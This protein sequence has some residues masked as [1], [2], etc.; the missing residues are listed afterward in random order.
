[1]RKRLKNKR[2]LKNKKI[3]AVII[4]LVVFFGFSQGL[5][6]VYQN[7][8]M[9]RTFVGGQKIGGMSANKAREIISFQASQVSDIK[10][11]VENSEVISISKQ[12]LGVQ[13]DIEETVK[14][15]FS[16]GKT[17]NWF[18]QI[19]LHAKSLFVANKID[20]VLVVDEELLNLVLNEKV[21]KEHESAAQEVDL[22]IT[23]G[24]VT[25]IPGE[26]GLVL[27]KSNLEQQIEQRFTNFSNELI[28]VKRNPFAP[29]FEV[30]DAQ[31]AKTQA[32]KIIQSNLVL[33]YKDA[34]F[35]IESA[36][37]G[38][39]VKT[40]AINKKDVLFNKAI[41]AGAVNK[42]ELLLADID[43][44]Q[45]ATYVKALATENINKEPK[46]AKVRF[47]GDKVE[48]FEPS[49]NGVTVKEMETV[50][51]IIDTLR[52]KSFSHNDNKVAVTFEEI[53][54]KINE[55]S[56]ADSGIKELIGRAA[57]DYATSPSNRKHNIAQGVK[58]IS[59]TILAPNEEFSAV[60][61]LGDVS[62]ATGY[63]PELVISNNELERQYG[64]GL[65]Q[66]ITTLFRAVLDAGLQISSRSNHSRRVSYY[67]RVS[68]I[69]GVRINWDSRFANIGSG[70]VGYDATVFIP[71]PDLKFIN[72]TGH[73]ILVQGIVTN[74]SRVTFEIYGTNDDRQV[75][76]SKAIIHYTKAPPDP[77][78]TPDPTK[79]SMTMELVEKSVPG[80]KTSF[81]YTVTKADGSEHTDT[82]ES[83]YRPIPE[84]YLVGTAEPQPVPEG[85]QPAEQPAQ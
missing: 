6:M 36:Q 76:I 22:D 1:M 58:S 39:W 18:S 54:P 74:N 29:K 83:F 41:K 10:I 34:E 72:D 2:I 68:A 77:Q 23:Q 42:K 46:N 81:N 47:A 50:E 40:K 31:F 38:G 5:M 17:G 75:T 78:F 82:F 24:V 57:T 62:A 79:P 19:L 25:I 14:Q 64:G 26:S 33:T 73:S 44:E 66:P 28:V 45:V 16:L 30:E 59:G 65:C 53:E 56:L 51:A 49:S 71:E 8:I 70:L 12:E 63:L 21:Y 67:E 55:G 85:E 84:R 13:Y 80:A 35:V 69:K 60:E 48:V 15:A 7:K 20:P 27:D 3:I 32:E 11:Q 52:E 37:L 43:N 61:A 4:F 9:P